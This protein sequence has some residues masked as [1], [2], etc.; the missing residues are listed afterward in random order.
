MV[1]F[2]VIRNNGVSSFNKSNRKFLHNYFDAALTGRNPFVPYHCN[3]H[4]V[5]TLSI[6]V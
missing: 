2:S 3:S 5:T 6:C 1:T 4:F